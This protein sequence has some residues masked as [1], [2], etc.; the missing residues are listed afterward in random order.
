MHPSRF[1]PFTV[2]RSRV[3]SSVRLATVALLLGGGVGCAPMGGEGTATE[4]QRSEEPDQDPAEPTPGD[5]DDRG[6]E[7]VFGS[8]PTSLYW[9]HIAW[10]HIAWNHIAWN[11]I[12]WNQLP[13]AQQDWNA[14]RAGPLAAGSLA[15]ADIEDLIADP[16]VYD[17]FGSVV[18][19]A[20]PY[21][22][23]LDF[24]FDSDGVIDESFSG[25]Y[26][27]EPSW[28]HSACDED[29][30]RSVSACIYARI[31]YFGE[32]NLMA[33]RRGSGIELNTHT[34]SLENP[35]YGVQQSFDLE[36]GA[37]WGN[38]FQE[39]PEI[40]T[41]R[42]EDYLVEL[43]ILGIEIDLLGGAVPMSAMRMCYGDE[44]CLENVHLGPCG[45]VCATKRSNGGYEG[46]I[47]PDGDPS[48]PPYNQV[49]TVRRADFN[50]HA[51][52]ITGHGL[53]PE[54]SSCA[55]HVSDVDPTC[56]G[57]A[58]AHDAG[59]VELTRTECGLHDLYNVGLPLDRHANLCTAY[60]CALHGYCCTLA[61]D[62]FCVDRA[63]T[64]CQ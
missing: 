40:Y 31:N 32:R 12:A 16:V 10:N 49:L 43:S 6:Q 9:N 26:G 14:L 21:D 62:L 59:C 48:D 61:W 51:D 47:A 57:G 41:C 13:Q 5:G 39:N 53:A 4:E 37:V 54:L 27:L 34:T 17:L 52:F 38:F 11:H 50:I 8:G 63:M 2:C 55:D 58:G 20:L 33:W 36:E 22:T 35:S 24:D 56:A 7:I 18:E 64:L 1:D 30:Q 19:C 3:L 25:A 28:E 46:C 60:V 23:A 15:S 42:G 44:E 29:C 45:D